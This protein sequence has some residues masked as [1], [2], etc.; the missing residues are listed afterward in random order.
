MK[1]LIFSTGEEWQRFS[2]DFFEEAKKQ[3]T[4]ELGALNFEN[5]R[6]FS[7]SEEKNSLE[8]GCSIKSEYFFSF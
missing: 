6:V 8:I 2:R 3:E 7:E 1:F 5:S 4:L